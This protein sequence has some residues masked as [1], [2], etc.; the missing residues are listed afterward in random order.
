MA[1]AFSWWCADGGDNT[2][3]YAW[4]GLICDD[5]YNTN[6]EEMQTNE[7]RSA[8]VRNIGLLSHNFSNLINL[9]CF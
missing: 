4:V 6:I 1:D 2:A 3:G 9:G 5:P 7:L 8:Y